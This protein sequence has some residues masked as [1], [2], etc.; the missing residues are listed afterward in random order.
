MNCCTF[1]LNCEGVRVTS[2]VQFIICNDIERP[3]IW[4]VGGWNGH[5]R[6]KKCYKINCTFAIIYMVRKHGS[7]FYRN[8]MIS[9][10]LKTDKIYEKEAMPEYGKQVIFVDVS[11]IDQVFTNSMEQNCQHSRKK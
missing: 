8:F 10:I 11:M 1:I 7:V 4:R 3:D 2:S 6:Q 5:W 9:S